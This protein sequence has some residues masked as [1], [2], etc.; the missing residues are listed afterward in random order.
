MSRAD[1]DR[2]RFLGA[3][4][5]A[6]AAAALPACR[7]PA[8]G[9]TPTPVIDTHLHC[10]AGR[11]SRH[12][13]YHPRATYRPRLVFGPEQLLRALDGGGVDYAVVVH[14]EPYQDDHSYLEHC[15]QVGG[16]RLKGTCLFFAEQPGAPARMKELA[17]RCPLVAARIH[18]YAPERLPPFGTGELRAFWKQA[19]DLG[20][21]VQL[22][23]APPYAEGFEPLIRDFPKTPVLID[24][25]G[26]PFMGTPKEHERIVRWA[27]FPSV[28]VKVSALPRIEEFPHRDITPFVERI[29]AAY[30]AERLMYGGD[31]EAG[32][33]GVSHRA[34]RQ[35]VRSYLTE[36]SGVELA[37]VFGGN[38]A[39]LF[40][41]GG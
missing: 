5:A 4:S 15:M 2:R 12:F 8:P 35:R 37:L 32:T 26:R 27:K 41:F 39:R 13:P 10:F 21:A 38:A 31:F 14:P 7:K 24:H 11:A 29:T 22:H 23:L 18:A 16:K 3:G 36:L 33:T 17:G 20:V 25:L 6:L 1:A 30:G 9:V 19:A 40:G 28:I 34:A